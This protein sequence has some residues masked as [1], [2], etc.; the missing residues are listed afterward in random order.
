MEA[1]GTGLLAWE[2]HQYKDEG[3][4]MEDP[5]VNRETLC[6]SSSLQGHTGHS[7]VHTLSCTLG[8]KEAGREE[9]LGILPKRDRHPPKETA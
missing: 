8:R 3:N 6:P 4:I 2:R 5:E 1:L 7:F 9:S